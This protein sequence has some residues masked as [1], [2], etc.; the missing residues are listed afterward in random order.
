MPCCGDV[1]NVILR[2]STESCDVWNKRMDINGELF[3]SLDQKKLCSIK[4]QF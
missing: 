2:F 1:I 4:K 3:V